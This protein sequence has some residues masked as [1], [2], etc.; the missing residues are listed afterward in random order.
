MKAIV[1]RKYGSPDVLHLEEVDEPTPGADE[2]LVK[3]HAASVNSWDYDLLRGARGF[4]RLSGLLKPRHKILGTD[5]A[6]RVEA[7]GINVEQLQ[8]GDEVFGEVSKRFISLGWGG[9][10]EYTCARE[11]NML[12]KPASMTF[13]QAA[14]LPQVAAL[15]LGGLRYNGE[16]Q[17]GQ[18]VLIN[19]AGGGVGTLAV[20]IAKTFGA[21]V[22]GVA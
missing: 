21:E 15:A 6:G 9:F 12:L 17:P 20:Q 16:I 13:E 4:T 10:A 22:T 14:S 11:K 7:V 1:Y 5:I 2:V 8:P 18:R 3:V 19:G